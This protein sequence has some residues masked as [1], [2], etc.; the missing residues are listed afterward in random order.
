MD[1]ENIQD[2]KYHIHPTRYFNYDTDSH[3]W[4]LE[5]HLPGVNKADIKLKMLPDMYELNA[6]RDAA[7]YHLQECFPFDIDVNSIKSS[8]ENGLLYINGKIK[9]PLAEAHEIKLT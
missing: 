1:N 3:E 2:Y 6:K 5:I 4:N 9:D 8:Y 7:L